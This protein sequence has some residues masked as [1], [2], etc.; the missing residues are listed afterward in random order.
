MQ[1]AGMKTG[2]Q[3]YAPTKLA[4]VTDLTAEEKEKNVLLFDDALLMEF[5][6]LALVTDLT[7]E[8][9]LSFDFLMMHF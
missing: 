4:L 9:F 1:N 5:M 6:K 7:A 8:K 3:K 2:C